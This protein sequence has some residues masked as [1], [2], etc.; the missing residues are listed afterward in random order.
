MPPTLGK[1]PAPDP[2]SPSSSQLFTTP[3][4]PRPSYAGPIHDPNPINPFSASP[5][6]PSTSKVPTQ[7]PFLHASS[8]RKLKELLQ[9]NSLRKVKER[10][11]DITPRTKARLRLTGEFVTPIKDK[12]PKRKRGEPHPSLPTNGKQKM[13]LE[14]ESEDEFGPSPAKPGLHRTFTELLQAAD[15]PAPALKGPNRIASGDRQPD[16]LGFFGKTKSRIK[17]VPEPDPPTLETP[18]P[19]IDDVEEDILQGVLDQG[20]SSPERL[21]T[22]P[23]DLEPVLSQGTPSK[24]ARADRVFT[25]SDGEDEWDPEGGNIQRRVIVTGTRR[26]FARRGSLSSVDGGE[27]ARDELGNQDTEPEEEDENAQPDQDAPMD[28]ADGSVPTL[29]I[30][31]TATSPAPSSPRSTKTAPMPLLS[32]LSLRSPAKSHSDRLTNLRVKAIF[33]PSDAARL[34]AT[35]RGQ[36]VYVSGEGVEG[37][38]ED[39]VLES[40]KF[41]GVQEA[42]SDFGDDD[43]EEEPEGWKRTRAGMDDW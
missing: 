34:K 2:K 14:V 40:Y 27:V 9:S 21:P 42:G 24:A 23:P 7:S 5:A 39:G 8:P 36:D 33:N 15:E 25:F 19:V 17:P 13:E 1:R 4:K 31:E 35:Q 6:R 22:P 29:T 18:T 11:E 30:G 41:D 43:W 12:P 20:E 28:D 37:D 32:L 10:Q 26:H 38:D 16:I 3:K